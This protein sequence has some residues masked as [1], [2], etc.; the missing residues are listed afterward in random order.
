MERRD[1]QKRLEE[2]Q[3]LRKLQE[4]QE[5]YRS[6]SESK[7]LHEQEMR[8]QELKQQ[9]LMRNINPD[10]R[11]S[12]ANNSDQSSLNNQ[13]PSAPSGN[14]AII[15]NDLNDGSGTKIEKNLLND[16]S[17]QPYSNIPQVPDRELKK[18]LVISDG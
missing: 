13:K 7:W 17:Q 14:L 2:E 15:R 1:E 3:K 10:S 6:E 8:L 18:N 4:E 12:G 16:P 11:I 9:E 5:R